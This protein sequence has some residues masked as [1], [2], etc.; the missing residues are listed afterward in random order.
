M[1]RGTSFA[2]AALAFGLASCSSDDPETKDT[3]PSEVTFPQDFMWGSA[4]AAFQVEKGLGNTDWGIWVKTPGKIKGGDDPD[5]GGAD[6]FAHIDEDV[7]LLKAANQN[8]Y[9]FSIDW[10]RVY[11]TR[12]AFDAD[13]PDAAAIAAY[14]KLFAALRAAGI[15]PFVTLQ[16]FTL[17]DY[18]SDPSKPEEPQGWERPETA[19]A[20]GTWCS[21]AA[22]RWGGEVD[23]WVTINEPL[24][25]PLAGYV[26]G[27]FPPGLV[28]KLN[29]ALEVGRQEVL[30]HAKC[31]DAVKAADTTDADGDGKAS[32]VGIVQHQRAVEPENP[33]EPADV[34]AVDRVRYLNNL[35]FL[36]AVVRGDWDDEFDGKLDGP[37]DRKG[38]PALANRSDFLGI[39]YYSALTASARGL[40]LPVVDAAIRLERLLTDRPKTDFNWDIYPEGLRVILEEVRP[41]NLP[42]VITENGIADSADKN[43][44]RFVLEHLFQLGLARESGLDIRGYMYWSL[45]DNFE[46]A[47]G[48]CPRFGLHTVDRATGQ[49]AVRP[50]TALYAN[51]AK[52][53]KITRAE[54]AALPPYAEPTY[55]E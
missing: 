7:A 35:W 20:F 42:I 32:W 3:G 24:V 1:S 16:H 55:C 52:T 44:A 26:Q 46:W 37:K 53:G 8:T 39:N 29:R 2:V 47:H 19:T 14:D 49:R 4:S 31:Y 45:L 36:N 54:I 15:R 40:V 23:W 13:Q 34:A 30:G 22:T 50:S 9:R 6:A 41:Y 5:V 21:R 18:L 28:L 48:F 12:E 43:R 33:D 51:A 25:A 27:S 10:A 17:P 11:P 38:D